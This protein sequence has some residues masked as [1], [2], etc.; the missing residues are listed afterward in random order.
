MMCMQCS[1]WEGG[2]GGGGGGGG[3]LL[4]GETSICFMELG[5]GVT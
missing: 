5:E 2:G 3:A 4:K 1:V